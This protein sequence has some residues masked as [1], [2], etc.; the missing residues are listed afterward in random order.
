M[1]FNMNTEPTICTESTVP[2][3]PTVKTVNAE[4]IEE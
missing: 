2:T 4:S 1:L 3:N